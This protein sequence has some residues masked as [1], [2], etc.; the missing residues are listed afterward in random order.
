MGKPHAIVI[1]YPA[2]GHVLPM[3]ELSQCLVRHKIKVTFVN[4]EYNHERVVKSLSNSDDNTRQ[5]VNML[6][7]RDGVEPWEDRNDLGKLTDAMTRVMPVELGALIEKLNG[8]GDQV[9]CVIA[10][11]Q[12][13]WAY[14]VAE[15]ARIKKR[16][17]GQRRRRR[18]H[19][20]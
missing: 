13:G 18:W 7:I 8:D 19:C 11:G 2:Q 6:S 9:T 4:T 12:F 10:D 5:M 1:P 14:E 16:V 15:R 17:S 3:M 20:C